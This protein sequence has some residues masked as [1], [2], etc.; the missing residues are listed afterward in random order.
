[1]DL[2]RS[3]RQERVLVGRGLHPRRMV[4][5][6]TR[7]VQPA[8]HPVYALADRMDAEFEKK[9]AE[10]SG[11]LTT[12]PAAGAA[13]RRRQGPVPFKDVRRCSK[14]WTATSCRSR[15][16][17]RSTGRRP[18]SPTTCRWSSGRWTSGRS[19]RS[20]TAPSRTRRPRAARRRRPLVG[21]LHRYNGEVRGS[22][23]MPSSCASTRRRPTARTRRA[24]PSRP[25]PPEAA[26]RRRRRRRAEG[27]ARA[28]ARR[29]AEGRRRAEAEE[30]EAA[31][32]PAALPPAAAAP[33]PAAAGGT[34][35]TLGA[36]KSR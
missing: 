13:C 25:S 9:L 4:G 23:S 15:S 14:Y 26:R 8:G 18:G 21:E 32:P 24:R 11:C 1:M 22:R 12:A 20:S 5:G 29:C 7:Q 35:I 10:L 28:E 17:R 19:G 3:A 33:P 2:G 6:A 27:R 31:P 36:C 16:A 30:P 34:I